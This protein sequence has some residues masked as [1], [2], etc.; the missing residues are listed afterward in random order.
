MDF[1]DQKEE[2]NYHLHPLI[3]QALHGA[4]ELTVNGSMAIICRQLKK[5]GRKL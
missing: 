4:L 1:T 3:A 2:L 5:Q